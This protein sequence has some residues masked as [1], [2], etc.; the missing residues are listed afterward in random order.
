MLSIIHI[1]GV[2]WA[3]VLANGLTVSESHAGAC[4]FDDCPPGFQNVFCRIGTSHSRWVDT[5]DHPTINFE[6]FNCLVNHG[7]PVNVTGDLTFFF[8]LRSHSSPGRAVTVTVNECTI[9][10]HNVMGEDKTYRDQNFSFGPY[11]RV[12]SPDEK[13]EW[14]IIAPQIPYVDQAA[15]RSPFSSAVDV[16]CD[17][18]YRAEPP[19]NETEAPSSNCGLGCGGLYEGI[20]RAIPRN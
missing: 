2:L 17:F 5:V 11:L 8:K 7:A 14:Y 19:T 16:S 12:P 4:G 10:L 20:R 1:F 9:V 18:D 13:A 3:L 6:F 15:F